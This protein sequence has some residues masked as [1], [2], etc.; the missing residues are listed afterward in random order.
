MIGA[1]HARN[2]QPRTT[3]HIVFIML[4]PNDARIL[5]ALQI[6]PRASF[7]RIA[8][9]LGTQEQA[10]ARRYHA[11]RRAGMVRVTG[12]VD[13][14]VYGQCQWLVRVHTRPDQLARLA[15]ALAR[16]PEVTHANV[17][18]GWTELACLV[19]A[20]L[21]ESSDGLLQRLPRTS[22]VLRVDVDLVLHVFGEPAGAI[23]T[24]TGHLSPQQTAALRGAIT[25]QPEQPRPPTADDGV[26]LAALAQD[27]RLS[28]A[29][30][31]ELTGWS[32]ARVR[33]RIA[34]LE[35]SGTLSFDV[36]VLPERFGFPVH[37]M[38]WMT[39]GPGHLAS[40]AEQ[41]AEH[42][43]TASVVAISGR[44]NLVAVAICRDVDHLYRYVV[45]QLAT[46]DGI[47]AYDV[48]IRAKRLKQVAS[49]VSNGRLLTGM[50]S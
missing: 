35:A 43:E 20:P 5:H 18:S 6:A 31:G 17:L 27:G 15:E 16:R 44:H 50:L 41:L 32:P 2:W 29:R 46:V 4:E 40:A 11:M 48:S 39:A 23:W 14:R 19:R 36:D 13:P 34:A 28:H 3:I 47:Q 8:D 37:A 12:V 10:V 49:L 24:G 22:S 45:D 9:V 38:V 25:D 26:L 1:N 42:A 30:L 7:R 33:R 21:G